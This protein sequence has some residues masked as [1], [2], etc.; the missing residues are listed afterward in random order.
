M[1]YFSARN[2]SNRSIFKVFGNS[3]VIINNRFFIFVIKLELNFNSKHFKRLFKLLLSIVKP[4]HQL[5][6]RI[7]NV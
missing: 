2:Y 1:I 3:I 6:L 4:R 5:N 7:G